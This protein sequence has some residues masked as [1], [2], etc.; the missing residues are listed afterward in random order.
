[1]LRLHDPAIP[2]DI[3]KRY[4][5]TAKVL[6]EAMARCEEHLEEVLITKKNVQGTIFALKNNFGWRD[7]IE[8]EVTVKDETVAQICD[9]AWNRIK[10]INLSPTEYSQQ[11]NQS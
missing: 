1:L 3:S 11:N 4:C 10:T 8:Q 9:E 5:E 7:K 2:L 6:I